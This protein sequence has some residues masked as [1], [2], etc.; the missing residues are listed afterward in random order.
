[1]KKVLLI[2]FVCAFLFLVSGCGDKKDKEDSN[3]SPL[4]V[5]QEGFDKDM[6][7]EWE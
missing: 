4:Q 3:T 1:M 6:E 7:V 5:E 2:V